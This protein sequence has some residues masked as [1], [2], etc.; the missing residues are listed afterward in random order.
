MRFSRCLRS[1]TLRRHLIAAALFLAI[2]QR[3]GVA[4]SHLRSDGN[5]RASA[6]ALALRPDKSA[7][8]A[9]HYG[10]VTFAGLP[11]PGATVTATQGDLQ[12]TTV[13]DQQGVYRFVNLAD[14]S[15]TIRV[16]MV[17]FS[18][19]SETVTIPAS[20]P[21]TFALKLLPFS[22]VTAGLPPPAVEMPQ[23]AAPPSAQLPARP[24]RGT[25][26]APP[27]TTSGAGFQRA[28]VNAS[29]GTA[30][31]GD[32]N[33]AAGDASDRAADA[34]DGFLINGSV[35][36]GAASPFAQLPAFGN[37]RRGARSLYNGGLGILLGNSAWDSRPFSFTGQQ[38]PK[39]SYYDA[40]L[41]GSFAGPLKIPRVRTRPNL[42]L[43]YQHTTDHNASTQS[44][45]VPTLLER[46]GDFS[47]SVDVFGRRI[48]L[49]DPLTGLPF[50]GNLPTSTPAAAITTRRRSCWRRISTRCSRGLRT[51]STRRTSCSG[52]WPISE[53]R[54][55]RRTCSDLSIPTASRDST[56]RST[57][58]IAFR[59]SSRCACGINSRG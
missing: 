42:F 8:Q 39:L 18:P 59:R 2:G 36:N 17:G 40:Q 29:A 50:A 4:A 47:Q 31:A 51:L 22:H 5:E 24:T 33:P 19:L 27:T 43:G 20:A 26:P 28:A 25:S 1:P 16:E 6:F 34:A 49:V 10:Q 52:R 11:V 44:A 30:S 41:L 9:D 21:P 7:G 46:S 53:R 58:R 56:C 57:G 12:R 55:T 45:L 35:N 48:E 54:R 32:A 3:S 37:N 23:P 15:W 14:G 38:A 13:T